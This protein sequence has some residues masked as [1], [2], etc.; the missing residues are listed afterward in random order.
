MKTTFW[1]LISS[2]AGFASGLMFGY[3]SGDSYSMSLIGGCLFG[4]LI[5]M[6]NVK[7]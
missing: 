2:F 7:E 1:G 3:I 6:W 5:L 4:I